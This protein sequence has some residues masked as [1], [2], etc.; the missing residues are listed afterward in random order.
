MQGN[1][2]Q[3]GGACENPVGLSMYEAH[4]EIVEYIWVNIEKPQE[5]TPSAQRKSTGELCKK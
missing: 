5:C 1:A 4:M 3:V 2:A